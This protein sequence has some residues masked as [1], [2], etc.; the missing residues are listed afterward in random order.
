MEVKTNHHPELQL[1][2]SMYELPL[3]SKETLAPANLLNKSN[4]HITME[5][6]AKKETLSRYF[7]L[8]IN[9]STFAILSIFIIV[10]LS[11]LFAFPLFGP[12]IAG[13]F[14]GFRALS[15]EKGKWVLL[16]LASMATSTLASGYLVDKTSKRIL[17]ILTSTLIV[18]GIT[19]AFVWLNFSD[20]F[21]PAILLGLAAGVS[22][23]ALGAYFADHSLPEDRGRIMGIAVGLAIAM[24]QLFLISEPFEIG[25]TADV[26]I[27]TIGS[28]LL[29]TFLALAFR[30]QEKTQETPSPKGQGGLAPRQVILYAI[31]IFLF[32]LVAG[33]LLSIVFPTIQDN[34]GTSV[35]YLIWAIPFII[36]AIFAGIELDLRGRKFPT[37]IGLAITGV[38]LA[39]FGIVGLSVGYVVIIPLAIGYSF[40]AIS[41]L[42]I[43]ADLAPAKSRG[44]MYGAGFGLIASAQMLGLI[45]TGVSFGSVS[46]SQI[47]AYM[48]FSSV[49]LFLCIPPLLLAEEA[50]PK[51]LIEKRKLL[52]Y[53]DGVKNKFVRKKQG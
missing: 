7:K 36:G 28:W 21:L 30:P 14:D 13:Y 16:F 25:S 52:E 19:F 18:S 38:S 24:A 40:V 34:V 42:I 33:I 41:S 27:L 51:E 45:I 5:K 53:L 3:E 31:P 50:L 17:L 20:S 29:I 9:R 26:K 4:V 43:W 6:S 23:V 44:K 2:C 35:F 48:L 12:I 47:N 32:Y 11:W 10:Y 37:I 49:A 15:I 39:V 8:R 1:T 46:T 22:P